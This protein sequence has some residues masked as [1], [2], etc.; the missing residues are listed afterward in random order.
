[1]GSY[2]AQQV[3]KLLIRKDFKVA[4]A[5]VLVLCITFKENCPDFRNSRMVD[6]I[7]ELRDYG[8]KV[9]VHDPRTSAALVRH[10]YGLDLC[11]PEGAN[12]AVVAAVAHHEFVGLDVRRF[13]GPNGVVYDIMGILGRDS[14]EARL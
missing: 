8:C 9:E 10:E 4:G 6:V 5:R 3:V 1:M 2:V 11:E 14:V 7:S 13:C 12:D